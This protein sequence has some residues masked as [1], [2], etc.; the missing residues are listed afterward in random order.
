MEQSAFLPY[1]KHEMNQI[2][3]IR[4]VRLLTDTDWNARSLVCMIG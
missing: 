3:Q 4:I 1:G 2:R